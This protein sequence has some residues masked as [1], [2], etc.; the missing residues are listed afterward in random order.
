M[1][2][3]ERKPYASLGNFIAWLQ[4][5]ML[6]NRRRLTN[7][8]VYSPFQMSSSTFADVKKGVR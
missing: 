8:N 1:S 4:N 3:E 7:E 2:K 6:V 5:E